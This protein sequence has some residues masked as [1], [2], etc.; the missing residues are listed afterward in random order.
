MC[1]DHSL[2]FTFIHLFIGLFIYLRIH[3]SLDWLSFLF[4]SSVPKGERENIHLVMRAVINSEQAHPSFY[5]SVRLSLSLCPSDGLSLPVSAHQSDFLPPSL[6]LCQSVFPSLYFPDSPILG[7]CL[8]PS[9]FLFF[10]VSQKCFLLILHT[11][12]TLSRLIM[13][14]MRLQLH[15]I[16]FRSSSERS[17]MTTHPSPPD[18]M[19]VRHS[20]V[21]IPT[22]CVT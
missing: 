15:T 16:V 20:P 12:A 18:K 7:P 6:P 3:Y 1:I 22:F 2:S 13:K 8:S 14:S 17:H 4:A 19:C 5:S 21:S 11:L 9:L 10:S